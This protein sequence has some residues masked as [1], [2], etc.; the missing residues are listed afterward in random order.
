M[1]VDSDPIRV[2]NPEEK[3]IYSS[4]D[5]FSLDPN[6]IPSHVAIMMDGNRRWAKKRG[7]P[8]IMGHWEG[9]EVLNEVTRGASELG[10]KTLTVYSFSTEN[11]RRSEEEIEALMNIFELYLIRRKETMVREGVRLNAIGNLSRFPK[12]VQ[13]AFYQTK[14]ATEHCDR[15][16]LV[17]AM[18]YGGR[19]EIRRAILKIFN[20]VEEG[21]IRAED[22]TEDLISQFMDTTPWG[23]PD[24]IIRTS[25]EMRAS[26]FLLWQSYYAEFFVTNVLWPD[27]SPQTLLD[28]VLTFQKRDRRLGG[29]C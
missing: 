5:L 27:F 17:L 23:D 14:R 15:I 21:K 19:D 29:S 20:Q 4:E 3:T 16:N 13:E 26:N 24:L 9:A 12:R 22:L 28:A 6:T 10:I 11:W 7:L 18:N 1:T 2:D 8:P 25:G